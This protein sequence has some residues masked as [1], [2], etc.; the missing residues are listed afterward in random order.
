ME[1]KGFI[2]TFAEILAAYANGDIITF[3]IVPDKAKICIDVAYRIQKED[4]FCGW[5]ERFTFPL[6]LAIE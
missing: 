3:Q 1:N 4:V 5:D 2:S 6:P